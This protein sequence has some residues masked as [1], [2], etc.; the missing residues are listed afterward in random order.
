M[1]I[2]SKNI[3][4]SAKTDEKPAAKC[5]VVGNSTLPQILFAPDAIRQT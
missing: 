1:I 4:G 5:L 2:D 3:L